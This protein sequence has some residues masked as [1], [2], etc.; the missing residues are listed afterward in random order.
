MDVGDLE[1]KP[2]TNENWDLHHSIIMD[3]LHGNKSRA[4]PGGENQLQLS[5]R[6]QRALERMVQDGD[7]SEV[8]AVTHGG[9][10]FI[11]ISDICAGLDPHQ[12]NDIH[13]CAITEVLLDHVD[14]RIK[15]ELVSWAENSHLHDEAANF[16]SGTPYEPTY[17]KAPAE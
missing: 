14:G 7:D 16:V 17:S 4:F 6:M 10:L 9:I 2:P 3:W 13:N 8:I 15:G 11:T 12:L 5:Q 1:L